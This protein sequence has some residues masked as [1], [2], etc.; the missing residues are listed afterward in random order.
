M[1]LNDGLIMRRK[2]FI[3]ITEAGAC[4]QRYIYIFA[5]LFAQALFDSADLCLHRAMLS[6]L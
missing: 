2:D 3:I 6:K 1:R 5:P 4:G